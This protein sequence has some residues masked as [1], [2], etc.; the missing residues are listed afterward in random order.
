MTIKA[1]G[2]GPL[3]LS[4]ISSEFGGGNSLSNFYAGG[5]RVPAGTVGYPG[6]VATTIPS[7]G[8]IR[9]SNFYG[10]DNNPY[11]IAVIGQQ[12]W[13]AVS[14]SLV[15]EGADWYTIYRY[16]VPVT[17]FLGRGSRRVHMSIQHFASDPWNVPYYIPNIRLDSPSNAASVIYDFGRNHWDEGYRQI[18]LTTQLSPNQTTVDLYMR[19]LTLPQYFKDGSMVM[20]VQIPPALHDGFAPV[21][22]VTC[23]ATNMTWQTF[24]AGYGENLNMPVSTVPG[25]YPN[26]FVMVNGIN[27]FND[28]AGAYLLSDNNLDYRTGV[29]SAWGYDLQMSAD[30]LT[31]STLSGKQSYISAVRYLW[32]K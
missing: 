9:V 25:N 5:A 24:E 8:T 32:S 1:W 4:E 16:S 18:F 22:L 12:T 6:G 19:V 2:S 15:Q 10:A 29:S 28:G 7:S 21:T 20:V 14:N 11:Q 27:N 31:Y 23:G 30:N 3:S 17:N 13:T 26:S